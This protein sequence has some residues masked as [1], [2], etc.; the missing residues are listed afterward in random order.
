MCVY[1][2]SKK[3]ADIH[4]TEIRNQMKYASASTSRTTILQQSLT[5]ISADWSELIA[6]YLCSHK[7]QSAF[8]KILYLQFGQRAHT[9]IR[10]D[11]P[12]KHISAH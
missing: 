5:S 11:S 3:S 1:K 9:N 10:L 8:N 2:P 12:M 6:I 4:I 7:I